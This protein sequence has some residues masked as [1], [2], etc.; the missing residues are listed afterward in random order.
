M[1]TVPQLPKGFHRNVMFTFDVD[2]QGQVSNVKLTQSSGDRKLDQDLLE[3]VK[4]IKF[5]ERSGCGT[6][7]VP[8]NLGPNV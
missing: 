7:H 3:K 6:Y 2:E 5:K 4:A 8:L 1:S